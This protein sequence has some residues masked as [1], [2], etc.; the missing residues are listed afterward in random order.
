M[1]IINLHSATFPTTKLTWSSYGTR[2]SEVRIQQLPEPW[3]GFKT[4][5]ILIYTVRSESRC[6]LVLRYV[7]FVVSIDVAVEVR[8]RFTIFSC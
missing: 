7:D 2:A 5:F 8:C 1:Y 3:H 4:D 6:A